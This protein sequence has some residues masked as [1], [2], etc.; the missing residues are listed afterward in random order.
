MKNKDALRFENARNET[1]PTT[2]EITAKKRT[3][4]RA[5]AAARRAVDLIF[6]RKCALCGEIIELYRPGELCEDCFALYEKRTSVRCPVCRRDAGSCVCSRLRVRNLGANVTALGFYKSAGDEV[7]RLIYSFKREY[8]RDLTRFFSRSLASAVMR[9][10]A[11][12]VSDA[13]VT[14]PP[15]SASALRKYGFDHARALAR[16]TA[17]YLGADFARTLVRRGGSEQKK[18]DA[19][20]REK[21][22]GGVF[23]ALS[24]RAVA[25]RRVILV[26][27]VAT[28]GATLAEAARVL[29]AS[30]AVDVRFAVLFLTEKKPQQDS[31][32]IWF[33]DD[34]PDEPID[35][36]TAD[37]VGF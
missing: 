27:D 35:D 37:D 15:R 23:E 34:S 22:V 31:G 17:R 19:A 21:N 16:E 24:E 4:A 33:E 28:T 25:G 9:F 30:G 3:A 20:E 6:P 26:D 32:G 5:K 8:S 2:G 13:I 10:S 11:G 14:F 7:G 12:N 18:L 29:L 36:P 1:S